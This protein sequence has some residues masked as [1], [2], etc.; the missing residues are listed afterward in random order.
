MSNFL[1]ISIHIKLMTIEP[2]LCHQFLFMG[3]WGFNNEIWSGLIDYQI[4]TDIL[5]P[6]A[7][8]FI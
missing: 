3:I 5:K 4:F 2:K 6:L 8:N 1:L 7:K